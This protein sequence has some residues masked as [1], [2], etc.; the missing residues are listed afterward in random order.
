MNITIPGY[1]DEDIARAKLIVAWCR[2]DLLSYTKFMKEDYDVQPFHD[3][4]ADALMKVHRWEIKRLAI[5]MPP[6][7]WKSKLACINFPTWVLGHNPYAKIV[8]AWYGQQL[9]AE[10]SIEARNM[11]DSDKYKAIFTTKLETEKVDHRRTYNPEDQNRDPDKAGYYH[12]TGIGWGLTGYWGN[13]L[14]VDDPVK[15]R[16]EAESA[17]YRE[18]VW[19]RYTS[20]LSTRFADDQSAIIVI[21]TR[22]H[23]DDL[24]WRIEKLSDQYRK[25]WIDP[26]PRTLISIPALTRDP[27]VP[28]THPVEAEKWKSFRPGRFSTTYLLQK[29][30]D[31]GIRDFSALYQQDPISSTWAVF[32]PADFRYVKLSDFETINQRQKQLYRKEH[33]ELRAI[34]D[35][36]FSTDKDSDDASISI[37]GK[38]KITKEVFLFDLYSGTSAPSVTVDYLFALLRKRRNRWFDNIGGISIEYVTLNKDQTEF[39]ETVEN[40]MSLRG[41]FYKLLKRYPKW[42]KLDRIRFSLEPIF[43]VHKLYFL[44]DQ[45]PYEQMQKLVEQL[46]QFPNSNKKDVIDVLSQWVIVFRD[47]GIAEDQNKPKPQPKQ[48]FNPITGQKMQVWGVA[49]KRVF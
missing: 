15:N 27:E 29:K 37:M 8:V 14:I 1:T 33:I 30:I 2:N 7:S 20:T 22:W 28:T 12:A 48:K 35:P 19:N 43:S 36:A 4:I 49:K 3:V 31:I 32:K 9:P 42:N 17:V 24:R 18:K 39:F 44:D 13:I 21:M 25:A 40:E 10:F 11:L 26:E 6:R 23:I 16:D 34:V 46:Q 41:E 45:I 38:H 5:E 47:W